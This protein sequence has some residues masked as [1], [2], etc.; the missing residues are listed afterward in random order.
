MMLDD[1]LIKNTFLISGTKPAGPYNTFNGWSE[2]PGK[3]RIDYIMVRS[4]MTVK[5][6]RTIK[7]VKDSVYI[8]DHWP[9]IAI[10]RTAAP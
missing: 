2:E 5:S 10:M 4:G 9:V 6:C 7:V 1:T 3:G 8:S